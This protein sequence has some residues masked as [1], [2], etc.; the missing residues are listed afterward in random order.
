M[1]SYFSQEQNAL[2]ERVAKFAKEVLEPKAAEID[3][4][5]F[6]IDHYRKV[7]EAGFVGVPVSKADG[8]EGMGTVGRCILLEEISRVCPS[9]A[10]TYLVG[11]MALYGSLANDELKE[12]YYYPWVNGKII[13]CFALTEPGAGSDVSSVKTTAVRDGDEYVINGYKSQATNGSCADVVNVYAITDPSVKVSRG[14]SMICVPKGTPGM[15]A[16]P[17][18]MATLRGADVSEIEFKDC[19]V[20]VTNLVGEENKGYKYAMG[21]IAGGRINAAACSIGI[22]IHAVEAAAEYAKTRVQFGK[23]IIENQ[24]ISFKLAEMKARIEAAKALVYKAAD[25]IDKADPDAGTFASMAKIEATQA[26]QFCADNGL[27]IF[28]GDGCRADCVAQRIYR[29]AHAARIYD[30]TTEILKLVVGRTV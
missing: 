16:K 23:P 6:D 20:P 18:K 14:M 30:G 12:K 4:N 26:A 9:T 2:R 27:Q 7:M 17:T 3:E 1:D 21:G 15:I 19:R 13:A 28:G 8:G 25:M 5:G 29:D 10:L 24:A 22:G 11:G